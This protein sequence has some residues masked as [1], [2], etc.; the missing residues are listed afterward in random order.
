M[1]LETGTYINDLNPANPLGTDPKSQGDDQIRLL[2]TTVKNTFPF[3]TMGSGLM[4][5]NGASAAVSVASAADIVGY[6][7]ATAVTNATN[8]TNLTGIASTCGYSVSGQNHSYGGA[9]GP[10]VMGNTT[11]A[12]GFSLHRAGA[13]A[14]NV[15]LDTDNVF[16]IGGWSAS[17][18]RLQM[19]MS[20][21]LTMAGNVTAYSDE[22]LKKDWSNLSNNFI[23]QLAKVKH[24]IYTRIDD[25]SLRQVGVS[26]Q[27]LQKVIPEAVLEDASGMLTVS[28]GN[29]ALAACVELSKEVINLRKRLEELEGNK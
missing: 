13:Y 23:E 9:L 11:T 29:A 21:N 25:N 16:R 1:G 17:A 15:A 7:G 8:A 26:A 24:G 19:D 28:Y 3:S 4:K 12:A 22:R 18:N 14:I 5:A 6:I 2:K 27:S 10:Q 20:G